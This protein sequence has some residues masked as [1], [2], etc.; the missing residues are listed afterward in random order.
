[1]GQNVSVSFAELLPRTCSKHI[2]SLT[3]MHILGKTDVIDN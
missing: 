2:A 3:F 1:M